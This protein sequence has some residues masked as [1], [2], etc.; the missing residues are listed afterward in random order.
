MNSA[1]NDP[2]SWFATMM[3]AQAAQAQTALG[4]DWLQFNKEQFAISNERQEKIDALTNK[5]TERQLTSM[6]NFNTWSAEDRARYKDVFLPLQDK[7][8]EKVNNWD[9]AEKQAMAAAEAKADV[10]NAYAEQQAQQE[11]A[12]AAKGIRPD[13]GAWAGTSRATDL[14]AALAS[15][16]AQNM[17]RKQLRNEALGLQGEAINMG[18]GLPGQ[19]SQA[20]ANG[21]NVG[22]STVGNN[23]ANQGSWRSNIGIM[24][25]GFDGAMAG[26]NSAAQ[27][28][29]NV[30]NDRVNMLN[31]SDKMKAD[32]QNAFIGGIG[33][34]VGTI[35]GMYLTGGMSGGRGIMSYAQA[36]GMSPQAEWPSF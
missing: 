18:N 7:F 6:D 16:G 20:L 12:M 34:A 33:S 11:R 27:I 24:N 3:Q 5:V 8:I 17:A 26:N 29:R 2:L 23:I 31:A 28:W 30:G 1:Q 35:G 13:S 22:N 15:A 14:G 10:A 9:S 21:A 25:T 19:A 32:A 4:K 36:R